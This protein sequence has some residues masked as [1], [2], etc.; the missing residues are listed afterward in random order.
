MKKQ[1]K[2]KLIEGYFSPSEAGKVVFAL[3]SSKIDYHS[4]EK[5][6]NEERF[7]KDA[8]HSEKRI[9]ALKKVKESL[10]KTFDAAEKRG[11]K[12]NMNGFIDIAIVD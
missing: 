8:A 12:I 2:F 5:F 4:M 6:S 7:G 9:K 11:L 1:H 3:I 10:K